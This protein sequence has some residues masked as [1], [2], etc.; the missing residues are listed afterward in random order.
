MVVDRLDLL[1]PV[2][3]LHDKVSRVFPW[4]IDLHPLVGPDSLVFDADVFFERIKSDLCLIVNVPY[5]DG[6]RFRAPVLRF[7]NSEYGDKT[8]LRRGEFFSSIRHPE[9]IAELGCAVA[10][11]VSPFTPVLLVVVN[12]R[13]EERNLE[14]NPALGLG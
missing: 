4:G 10:K 6:S 9:H 12:R 7:K 11:A 2:L 13:G 5:G 8:I 14:R 1:N 3:K